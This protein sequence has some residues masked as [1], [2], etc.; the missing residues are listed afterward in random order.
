MEG[1]HQCSGT[2]GSTNNDLPANGLFWMQA[3]VVAGNVWVFVL[4]S[5]SAHDAVAAVEWKGSIN[6]A[7]LLE[8]PT[9]IQLDLLLAEA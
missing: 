7:A 8:V 2:L 6:A 1:F 5:C 9:T 4:Q 3:A